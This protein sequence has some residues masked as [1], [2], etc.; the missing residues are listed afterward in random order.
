MR[1]SGLQLALG[2]SAVEIALAFPFEDV[3]SYQSLNRRIV[4]PDNTC[5]MSGHGD[6]QGYMCHPTPEDGGECCSA[7]GWCGES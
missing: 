6:G 1:L 4:S 2:L 3:R 7:A 5:G